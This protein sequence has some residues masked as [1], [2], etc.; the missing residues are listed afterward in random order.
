MK[1]DYEFWANKKTVKN[2]ELH[3][4]LAGMFF[5]SLS[6]NFL[7]VFIYLRYIFD[8]KFAGLVLM[9]SVLMF[10]LTP[11]IM[12]D[13]KKGNRN[14]VAVISYG[15]FHGVCTIVS[16]LVTRFWLLSIVYT[17]ELLIVI[18][19]LIRKGRMRDQSGTNQGTV[20]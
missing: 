4:K 16:I 12:M 6:F 17:I 20:L 1:K 11:I 2:L 9:L 18:L 7:L 14:S 13:P 8:Y 5:G 19:L 10:M 15:L 3:T